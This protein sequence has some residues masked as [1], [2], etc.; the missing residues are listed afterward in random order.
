MDLREYKR[1]DYW[2]H[3]LFIVVGLMLTF[4]YSM[5]LVQTW[6]VQQGW[7]LY[8][9]YTSAFISTMVLLPIFDIAADKIFIK[10][11]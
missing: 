4:P 6:L 9:Q 1:A 11:K 10:K 2:Y 8:V 3:I 5:N 7:S